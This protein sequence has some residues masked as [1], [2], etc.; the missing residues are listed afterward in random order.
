MSENNLQ[1]AADE[2]SN[3]IPDAVVVDD[4]V[5]IFTYGEQLSPNALAILS[6]YELILSTKGMIEYKHRE[7]TKNG[8][9]EKM[10]NTFIAK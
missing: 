1:K 4:K 3:I 6:E 5:I 2:L 9:D 10:V 7:L 8:N